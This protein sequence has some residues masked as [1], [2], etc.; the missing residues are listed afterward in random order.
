MFDHDDTLVGT[1]G[2]KWNQHKFFARTYYNKD[3]T[4]DEIKEHWG[5]P[6]PELVCLLY[7]TDDATEAI[8]YNI[9]HHESYPKTLF[10]HTL[11]VLKRLRR[12]NKKIGVITATIR[13]SFEHDLVLHGIPL[14]QFD[15][16]QTADETHHHKPNPKVFAPVQ[17]WLKAQ[18]IL[19]E[20]V[21]YIGDGLHDMGAAAGAGFGFIGVETGL[22]S[23]EQFRQAQAKSIRTI[24]DIFK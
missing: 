15:Y 22:V 12:D 3:L 11:E 5:K 14:A 21:V 20:E 9:K 7:G 16:T 17:D 18:N 19:P 13:F 4:D 10:P 24:G 23:P 2:P 8:E 6:L 1:I